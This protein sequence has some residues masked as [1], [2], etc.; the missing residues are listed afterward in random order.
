MDKEV[1]MNFDYMCRDDVCT[2]VVVYKGGKVVVTDYTDKIPL[3]AF[4]VWGRDADFGD[5]IEFFKTRCLP[6]TRVGIDK[7]LRGRDFSAE[8]I[9]KNV[10]HGVMACDCSWVRFDYEKDLTWEEVSSILRF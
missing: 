10:N 4:G 6:E 5:V 7:M 1:L 9:I 2:N 8:W 3:R